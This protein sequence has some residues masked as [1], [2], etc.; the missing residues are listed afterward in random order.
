MLYAIWYMTS[1]RTIN[2]FETNLQYYLKSDCLEF[3][4]PSIHICKY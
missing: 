4:Y 3:E 2:N 1:D